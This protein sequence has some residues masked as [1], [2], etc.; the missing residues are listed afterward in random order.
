MNASNVPNTVKEVLTLKNK[1]TKGTWSKFKTCEEG[2][3]ATGIDAKVRTLKM[4]LYFYQR[5]Y[6]II[7]REKAKVL[8]YCH[9]L[10]SR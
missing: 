3:Y 4:Y 2:S 5:L 8:K 10:L 7:T 1:N 6:M 9:L